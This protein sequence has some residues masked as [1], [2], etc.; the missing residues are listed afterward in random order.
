M[1]NI[2]EN[3]KV[4]EFIKENEQIVLKFVTEMQNRLDKRDIT[5]D[6][7]ETMGLKA[8]AAIRNNMSKITE[9]LLSEESKKKLK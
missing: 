2:R 3:K 5:I 8:I 9:T 4:A 1:E 6:D 7:I